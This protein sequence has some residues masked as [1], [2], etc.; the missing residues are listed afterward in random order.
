MIKA[1]YDLRTIILRSVFPFSLEPRY[2]YRNAVKN[3]TSVNALESSMKN[4][5][6]G[7]DRAREREKDGNFPREMND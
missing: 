3:K 1:K 6:R 7:R 4:E 5:K 2:E